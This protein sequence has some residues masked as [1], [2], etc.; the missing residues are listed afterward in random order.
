MKKLLSIAPA[1]V[2]S[3]G[4]FAG[5]AFAKEGNNG[6]HGN[7]NNGN[8]N[9]HKPDVSID[10][11]QV[12]NIFGNPNGNMPTIDPV[13]D[14]EVEGIGNEVNP[15]TQVQLDEIKRD[16]NMFLQE[17]GVGQLGMT[18]N[19]VTPESDHTTLKMEF[20]TGFSMGPITRECI[21]NTTSKALDKEV[22]YIEPVGTAGQVIVK[23]K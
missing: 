5:N 15:I 7:G 14:I 9:G 19:V 6:N 18:N 1:G 21:K 10:V 11:P 16:V 3:M 8:H 23:V 22:I 4:I 2:M 20:N 17:N 13:N 12:S